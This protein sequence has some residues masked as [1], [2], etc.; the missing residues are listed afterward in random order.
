MTQI[1][2]QQSIVDAYLKAAALPDNRY[3]RQSRVRRAALHAARIALIR[4]G[5][6][7]ADTEGIV[8]DARQMAALELRAAESADA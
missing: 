8:N 2:I 4:K 6:N 7:A 1:E 5:Y 3:G